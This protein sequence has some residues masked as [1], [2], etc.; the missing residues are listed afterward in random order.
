M[1]MD[2]L[3]PSI[4]R[5]VCNKCLYTDVELNLNEGEYGLRKFGPTSGHHFVF[6]KCYT[7]NGPHVFI[8]PPPPPQHE[9]NNNDECKKGESAQQ[10]IHVLETSMAVLQ[11]KVLMMEQRLAKLEENCSTN[12]LS[13]VEEE[14]DEDQA[15]DA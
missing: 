14:R 12:S 3:P 1:S 4:A 13:Q 8:I 5:P 2:G 9:N 7:D 11:R 6:E 15:N 10:V